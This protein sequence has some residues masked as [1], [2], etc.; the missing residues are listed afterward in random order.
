M[1]RFTEV[2]F[3]VLVLCVKFVTAL[4]V[5]AEAPTDYNSYDGSVIG[6][7]AIGMGETF[8]GLADNADNAFWNP[9]G[10]VQLPINMATIGFNVQTVTKEDV[11]EVF[12]KDPLKGGKLVYL[13]FVASQGG[14]SWRPLSNFKQTTYTEDTT[15]NTETW[16]EKEVRINQFLLS[17]AVPYTDKMNVGFNI[18]YLNGDLA[19]SSKSKTAGLWNEPSA[20]V[21]SGHGFGMDFG[22]LYKF[23]PYMN[24]G[25]MLQ[26]IASCMYWD[27]YDRDKLPLNMR[28][29]TAMKMGNLL[30]LVYDYE[31]RFYPDID[32]KEIYHLGMEHLFFKSVALRYGMYGTD[33][34]NPK[35]VT[36]TFG[37][38]YVKDNY[39]VDVALRKYYMNLA[40]VG[41][42]PVYSDDVVYTYICSLTIPF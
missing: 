36:Y 32:D 16:E 41:E 7:R 15:T 19:L 14:L 29:G 5:A 37:M 10:L 34:N 40:S 31:K 42:T 25:V 30:T 9:A 38:G 1:R 28:V 24:L 27:D 12:N 26:N 22:L 11:D 17:L 8:V 39:F 33:W 18:N 4:A 2:V 20:N 21:S 3:L 35:E 23:S 13:S 6:A